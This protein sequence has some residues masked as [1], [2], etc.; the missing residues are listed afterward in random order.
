VA[1]GSDGPLVAVPPEIGMIIICF[2]TVYHLAP[3]QGGR[4]AGHVSV[5]ESIVAILAGLL[6][7]SGLLPRGGGNA[8]S[9]LRP[10]GTVIGVVALV[11]GILSITSVTGIMLILGGLIL[12]VGAVRFVPRVGADLARA[13]QWLARLGVVV[14]LL[15]LLIGIVGLVGGLGRLDGRPR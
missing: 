5:L 15:L 10:F 13:G 4:N 3:P 11:A 12:A 6:L 2:V 14:G 9:A 8:I 7:I 1:H